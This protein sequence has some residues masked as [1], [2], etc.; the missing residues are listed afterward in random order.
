MHLHWASFLVFQGAICKSTEHQLATLPILHKQVRPLLRSV[1]DP[2]LH[3]SS[4]H[5][6]HSKLRAWSWSSF[7]ISLGFGIAG[8]LSLSL[9]LS[10]LRIPFCLQRK[11]LSPHRRQP[12]RILFPEEA[13]QGKFTTSAGPSSTILTE[14]PP[15][16][17]LAQGF[18]LR[19]RAGW[20][21]IQLRR[22]ER[23][24]RCSK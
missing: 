5:N 10:L 11:G 3:V 8:S 19:G 20:N 4:Q 2:A 6:F 21:C 17:F 7:V 14:S 9:S 12:E 15:L 13:A 16:L 23:L 18:S 24:C 1:L 22:R